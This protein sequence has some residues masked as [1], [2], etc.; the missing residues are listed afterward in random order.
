M[1]NVE[2]SAI[3]HAALTGQTDGKMFNALP[4]SIGLNAQT[5]HKLKIKH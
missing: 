4:M 2:C 3:R 1:L 5:L